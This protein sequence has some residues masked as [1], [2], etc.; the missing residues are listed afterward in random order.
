MERTVQGPQG[1]VAPISQKLSLAPKGSTRLAGKYWSH[2]SLASASTGVTSFPAKY[3][4]YNRSG[5]NP[6]LTVRQFHAISI[7]SFLK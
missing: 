3:V 7:A 5:F 6:K 4:A 2:K 1:P